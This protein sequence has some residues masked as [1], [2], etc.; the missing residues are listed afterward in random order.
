MG[1]D[2]AVVALYCDF[3]AQQ[4]Q[5]T[6][7]MLGSMLRQLAS[8]GEI[9]GYIWNAFWEAEKEFSGRGLQLSE[10]VDMLKKTI[11]S[12]PRLFIC[13]DALD[14]CTPKRRRELLESLRQIVRVSPGARVFFTGRPHIDDEIAGY[15]SKVL[16]IRIS[17]THGD[18]MNYLQMK[19]KSDIDPHAMDDELRVDIRR[20]VS[21]IS[22]R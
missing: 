6:T 15:F 12:V 3:H 4:E 18:I 17:P 16:R 7:N 9:P 8:R 10:M 14:E 20:I 11:R 22:E 2:G 5:S 19:L 21:H 1:K 13:I